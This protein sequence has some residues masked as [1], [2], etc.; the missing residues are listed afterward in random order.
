MKIGPTGIWLNAQG[1]HH[2]LDA[3]LAAAI[4][5]FLLERGGNALDAGCGD[6][7]YVKALRAAG[8]ECDGFDGNP[9]T[10]E[11]TGGLCGVLDFA[12]PV[13]LVAPYAWVLSLEVGEHI[14]C[15]Y[16]HVFVR[17][18]HLCNTQGVILSW[19][20]PGQ[21]GVGHLNE[22]SNEHVK[23]IFGSMGYRNDLEAEN[24]LRAAVTDCLWFRDTLMVFRR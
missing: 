3:G 6:G 16:E 18:L 9:N 7:S 15:G 8:I 24:T 10:R 17:N 22:R 20:V 1:Y 21:G 19:A 12:L 4:A 5:A 11:I 13:K 23:G 14:P 2:R